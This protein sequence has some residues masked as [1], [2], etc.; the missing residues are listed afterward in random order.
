MH[1]II[2]DP[3]Q[4]IQTPIIA[5]GSGYYDTIEIWSPRQFDIELVNE[6]RAEMKSRVWPEPVNSF[7]HRL[8]V[9]RP[10]IN[11]IHILDRRWEQ[12]HSLRANGARFSKWANLSLF[13][14]HMAF[15]FDVMP[16]VSKDYV[17]HVLRNN[18]HLKYRRDDD[19]I[20]DIGQ[21]QYAIKTK[22]RKSRPYVNAKFYP[23]EFGD[24][25]GECD[26]LH[27]ELMLER[28][29][30]VKGM[31]INRPSDL[32]NVRA[33]D[34][35]AKHCTVRDQTNILETI[36]QRNIRDYK[37][38][39]MYDVE[40]RVRQVMHTSRMQNVTVFKKHF[41]RQFER[42][43]EWE[44]FV[45]RPELQWATPNANNDEVGE[46]RILLQ[47]PQAHRIKRERLD[48]IQMKRCVH[49]VGEM[50]HVSQASN[51]KPKRRRERL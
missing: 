28:K 37:E 41:N 44:C 32:L 4:T 3:S 24:L 13:R 25:D 15:D 2:G 12:R 29:R 30:S 27:F 48:P 33:N 18:I 36:T 46:L 10:S 40:R 8:I 23:A 20:H 39:P 11:A 14:V 47:A 7:G 16:G 1:G 51:I 43:Q 21:T 31:R 6:L 34:W 9:N 22:G 42:L 38:H 26:K 50:S 35:F 19:E 5:Q 45:I 17:E 49:Q